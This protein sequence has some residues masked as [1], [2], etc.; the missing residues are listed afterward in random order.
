MAEEKRVGVAQRQS[1]RLWNV[2]LA[3]IQRRGLKI[4]EETMTSRFRNFLILL[5]IGGG[6]SQVIYE[7]NIFSR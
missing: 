1:K 7:P 3:S 2:L 5:V 4:N 6:L